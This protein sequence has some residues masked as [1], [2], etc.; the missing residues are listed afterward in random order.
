MAGVPF[1]GG[2]L[3]RDVDRARMHLEV[4]PVGGADGGRRQAHAR[5]VEQRYGVGEDDRAGGGFTDGL[6]KLERAVTFGEVFGIGISGAIGQ[7]NRRGEQ[8]ALAENN[9][10]GR[11]EEATTIHHEVIAAGED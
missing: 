9:A 4:L 11:G 6:A 2:A 8:S 1:T 10:T 7:E 3:D 5:A